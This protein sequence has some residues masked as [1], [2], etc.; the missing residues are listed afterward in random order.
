VKAAVK[1]EHDDDGC[2]LL[3]SSFCHFKIDY[4]IS[5]HCIT[6]LYSRSLKTGHTLCQEQ[7][8]TCLTQI[9]SWVE[10]ISLNEAVQNVYDILIKRL[11]VRQPHI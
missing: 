8:K 9:N 6:V 3:I 7:H 2:C 11:S 10:E 4:I 1:V 5:L